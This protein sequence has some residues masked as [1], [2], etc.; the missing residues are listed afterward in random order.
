MRRVTIIGSGPAGCYLAGQLFRLLPDASIDIVKRFG[1]SIHRLVQRPSRSSGAAGTRR[2][3]AV[4][5]GN[6]HVALDVAR[7]LGKVPSEFARYDLSPL[8]TQSE[9]KF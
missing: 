3:T 1:G 9:A 7:F 5:I 6:G 8:P 4:I 2:G